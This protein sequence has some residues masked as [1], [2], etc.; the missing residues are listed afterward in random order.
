MS[1]CV[2]PVVDETGVFR[3]L[4]QAQGDIV[5]KNYAKEELD[6]VT[7][8]QREAASLWLK[9]AYA[10]VRTTYSHRNGTL[11]RYSNF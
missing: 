6:P 1:S 8:K 5:E 2:P 10:I 11:S 4:V 3:E 7:V 9:E